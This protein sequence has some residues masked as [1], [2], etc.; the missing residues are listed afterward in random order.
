VLTI[1]PAFSLTP[2]LVTEHFGRGVNAV[3]LM[4]GLSGVGII[5]GGVLVSVWTPAHRRI[6]IVLA[7]FA[8]SC[9]TVAFTA[10]APPAVFGLAV[11]WWFVSGF[12][13]ST[14]NAPMM[15]IL[16]TVVPNEL[17][18]RVIS[19]L[20]VVIGVAGPLG[21]AVAG[22]LGEAFGVTAVFILGGLA[23]AFFCLAGFF[24]KPLREIE[25]A[26]PQPTVALR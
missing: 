22:P 7:S 10:L 8:L 6:D 16:Q 3:A 9:A 25:V 11:A 17:Q 4:E 19:L 5:L 14:G 18:G 2:L 23:A 26:V 1:L 21:L 24:S 15:A 12:T 20:N 13:F